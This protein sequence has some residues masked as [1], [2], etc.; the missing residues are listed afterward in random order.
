M[1]WYDTME[2]PSQREGV[3]GGGYRNEARKRDVSAGQRQ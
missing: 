2:G 3:G 1:V